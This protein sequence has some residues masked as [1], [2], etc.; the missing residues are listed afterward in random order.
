MT[1][2]L[3]KER[4]RVP[5]SASFRLKHTT[6]LSCRPGNFSPLASCGLLVADRLKMSRARCRA[7]RPDQPT[8]DA[9]NP[10]RPDVPC[11]RR[12]SVRTVLRLRSEIRKFL[13]VPSSS[14]GAPLFH[15]LVPRGALNWCR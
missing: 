9:Q 14:L 3:L 12:D 11:A 1:D 5:F 7:Q 15:A 2:C 4:P 13:E 10:E 6:A 8:V